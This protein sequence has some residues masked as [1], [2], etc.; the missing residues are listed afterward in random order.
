MEVIDYIKDYV[1]ITLKPSPVN[2]VGVFSLRLIKKGEILFKEWDG[3]SKL[4]SLKQSDINSLNDETKQHI[5]DMWSFEKM[6]DGYELIGYLNKGCHWIYKTPI[7]W[8][9]SCGWD[10]EP[11]VD[12]N[13]LEA[14]RDIKQG[15]EILFKYGKY[16]KY[17]KSAII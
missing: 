4:Y 13:T 2:G 15:E 11:N 5:L 8:V 14:L 17:T 6:G 16:N 10:E 7:H 1:N 3:D 9:N 12:R